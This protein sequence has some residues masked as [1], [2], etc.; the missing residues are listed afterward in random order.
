MQGRHENHIVNAVVNAADDV[1]VRQVQRLPHDEPINA[2]AIEAAELGLV[3]VRRGENGLLRIQTGASVVVPVGRNTGLAKR[4]G[5]ERQSDRHH[6]HE[7]C[8]AH[9]HQGGTV[10]C[11]AQQ[12]S[13]LGS[14]DYEF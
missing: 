3:Y 7:A 8:R 1:H 10:E 11:G 12:N 5:F 2:P 9:N 14:P 4:P 13:P 6:Y